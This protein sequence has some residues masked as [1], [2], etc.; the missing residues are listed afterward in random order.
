MQ[1]R[2]AW[3]LVNLADSPESAVKIVAAGAIP[4]LVALLRPRSPADV[5]A[6]AWGALR[7]LASINPDSVIKSGCRPP[8]PPR[9]P[10]AAPSSP[11]HA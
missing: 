1:E 8:A 5:Q 11:N 3:T 2:A 9:L 6:Q 7:S 10:A 4:P